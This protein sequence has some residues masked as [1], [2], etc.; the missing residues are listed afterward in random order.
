MKG[1]TV[2]LFVRQSINAR[3]RASW[4]RSI[5]RLL[6]EVDRPSPVLRSMRP[7]YRRDVA[8]ACAPALAEIRWVLDD[9]SA[10]VRP[11]AVRRL[12]DFLTYGGG[13]PL[14]GDDPKG[15]RRGARE[16]A[17]AF[18]VPAVMHSAAPRV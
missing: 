1:V 10:P 18:V 3:G 15:A 16:L 9:R 12:R 17:A 2:N 5:G 11:E 6:S 14:F 13:S 4:S 7:I 8:R